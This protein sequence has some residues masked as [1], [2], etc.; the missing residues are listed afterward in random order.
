M[1]LS[2]KVLAPHRRQ[3]KEEHE[4]FDYKETGSVSTRVGRP[5]KGA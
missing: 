3:D 2:M 5:V 4:T 1:S